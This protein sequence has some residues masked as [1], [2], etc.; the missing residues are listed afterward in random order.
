PEVADEPIRTPDDS[1]DGAD[2][3]VDSDVIDNN[4]IAFLKPQSFEAEQFKILRTKLLFPISGKPPRSIMITSSV[5][6]E[7]KSFVAA[8]LAIS[9]AQN[10]QE[11][12]LIIDCDMR[13]PSIHKRFGL[14]DVPGLSEYLSDNAPLSSLLLKTKIDK[15]SIL[16]GGRPPHNPAELLSSQRMSRLLQEVRER[17][18]DRYIIIDTPPPKLTAEASAISR[19]VDGIII[20]VKY[21]STSRAMVSELI[22]L[23]EKEKI[24]GIVLNNADMRIVNYLKYKIVRGGKYYTKYHK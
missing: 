9:I 17:Y 12:V 3:P 22:E 20:V 11:H 19:Q 15:L 6:G 5:P 7:G 4:L 13:M 16:P 23:V 18:P 8:N 2:A 1:S 21:G 14:G 10:I 24:L